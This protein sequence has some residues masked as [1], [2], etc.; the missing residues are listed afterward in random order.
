LRKIAA[1]FLSPC[2][3]EKPQECLLP[4]KV[5]LRRMAV[6]RQGKMYKLFAG[7]S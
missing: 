1:G 7:S 3:V 4:F 5:L 2:D 6:K